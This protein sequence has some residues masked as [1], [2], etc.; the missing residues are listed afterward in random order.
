M[1]NAPPISTISPRETITSRPAASVLSAS[2]VAAA[3]LLTTSA[4]SA[5]VSAWKRPCTWSSRS[6]RRPEPRSACTL[7]NPPATSASACC[8]ASESGARPR[9]VWSSTPV[10]L[11]ARRRL[12]AAERSRSLR[13]AGRDGV[14]AD[15]HRAFAR[16][17]PRARLG[18]R[19]ARG[20]QGQRARRRNR[21]HPRM[22][23]Q[24]VHARQLAQLR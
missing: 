21:G 9:L 19:L 2:T 15:V 7:Q 22:D 23:Q 24:V 8:A 3:L 4:A 18:H 17:E 14:R 11:T 6:E 13:G 10:A 12:D 16:Q 20:L 5:P 1:R